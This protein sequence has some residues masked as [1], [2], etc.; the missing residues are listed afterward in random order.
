MDLLIFVFLDGTAAKCSY[1]HYTVIKL[2]T[3]HCL[4]YVL[5]KRFGRLM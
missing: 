2:N 5:L 4:M 3:I 1:S